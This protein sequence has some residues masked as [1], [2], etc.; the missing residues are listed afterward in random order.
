MKNQ[1]N[2]DKAIVSII[3]PVYNAESYL[4]ECLDSVLAQSY[5]NLEIIL[6]N[7]GS[8]DSSSTICTKYA[9]QD[10]RVKFYTKNN[11]GVSSA[12]NLALEHV[13]GDFITF[14]DSDDFISPYF[15]KE[16]LS[17]IQNS[18][19]SLC[20][21][22]RLKNK[23]TISMILPQKCKMTR[24]QLFEYTLCSNYIS[25][26]LCTKMFRTSIVSKLHLRFNPA[27]KV[28]EDMLWIIQ[29]Y[30]ACQSGLY[31]NQPL[32]NYRLNEVSALQKMKST[33]VFDPKKTS[34][35]DSADLIWDIIKY[36]NVNIKSQGS[37][38]KVR[39]SLWMIF[40][41]ICCKYS[42]KNLFKR[43]KKNTHGHLYPF[44]KSKHSG[45]LEKISAIIVY[46][47][48]TVLFYLGLLGYK[49]FPN[50]VAKHL[51]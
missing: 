40:N 51:N 17:A 36:K 48:P 13:T 7:D 33:G 50:V 27:L 28:G 42:D 29:Y 26:Y 19:L 5:E 21:Y 4:E 23:E 45:V 14:I 11:G 1:N 32:Y 24:E 8:T 46:F 3:I 9:A 30:N 16:L 37:Y 10:I 35:L 22:N 18:D 49:L 15:V 44:L 47:S 20:G 43:I 25:G 31:V 34:N 6:V 41:M 39:T 38:R 12:R 2:P